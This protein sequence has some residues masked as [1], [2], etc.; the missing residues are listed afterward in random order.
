MCD[1][2]LED[3]SGRYLSTCLTSILAQMVAPYSPPLSKATGSAQLPLLG[4][5]QQQKL[6]NHGSRHPM[7]LALMRKLNATNPRHALLS[8]HSSRD[9]QP[10][11][12]VRSIVLK[13]EYC[14][15]HNN[16]PHSRPQQRPH[17]A[18]PR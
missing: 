2:K 1:A 14:S 17:I 7:Q 10:T 3:G 9:F 13:Y 4:H 18:R 11:P 16:S 5:T 12:S 8:T 15:T 6:K